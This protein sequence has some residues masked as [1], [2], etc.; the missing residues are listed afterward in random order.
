MA[1]SRRAELLLSAVH[2][3]LM[4]SGGR[5]RSKT[6][7]SLARKWLVDCNASS[8]ILAEFDG[9][10]DKL[11]SKKSWDYHSWRENLLK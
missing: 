9:L 3:V 2:Q 8:E 6:C 11:V 5:P 10:E 1:L 7:F 4:P